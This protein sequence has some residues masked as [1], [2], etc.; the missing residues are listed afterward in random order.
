[1]RFNGKIN[2]EEEKGDLEQRAFGERKI[3]RKM[4]GRGV[5]NTYERVCLR[6]Y[7]E[8]IQ[9]KAEREKGKKKGGRQKEK[10]EFKMKKSFICQESTSL[11]LENHVTDPNL[12][13]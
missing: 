4:W 5:L 13:G 3:C 2:N 10:G 1:V 8:S 12:E 6:S 7:S 11:I 9:E